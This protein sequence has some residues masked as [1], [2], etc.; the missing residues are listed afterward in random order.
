M[1]IAVFAARKKH[2]SYAR[3]LKSVLEQK[4]DVSVSILW[5]KN[6]WQEAGWLSVSPPQKCSVL[7]Q[8]VL[9]QVRTKQ[10]SPEWLDKSSGLLFF[11]YRLLKTAEASISY[12]VYFHALKSRRITALL[13]WNGLKFRQRICVEAAKALN[14][15]CYF[16]ERGA[17]PGTTTLDPK[18]INYLNSVPRDPAFFRSHQA[19]LPAPFIDYSSPRPPCLPAS[20]VFIPFQVNTDSQIVLFSPWIQNM[21]VLVQTLMDIYSAAGSSMP[22]IVLKTHPSCDQKYSA[23]EALLT[24]HPKIH[25]AH[26]LSTQDLIFHADAVATIN[27]SVGLEALLMQKKVIVMGQAFYDI[28]GITLSAQ[29]KAGL[30]DALEHVGTWKADSVL[31]ES[32]LAHVASDHIVNGRWQDASEEHLIEMS[33]RLLAL[34]SDGSE[35]KC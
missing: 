13:I 23:V 15:P 10:N 26:N 29:D 34:M 7:R 14:I 22:D 24:N 11:F 31:R 12:R 6:L 9:D 21:K 2:R 19:A 25:F 8:I 33:E 18:G 28:P 5:Y 16:I 1:R 4:P 32:F 30:K 35:A 17:F 3:K 27:S 20:Y